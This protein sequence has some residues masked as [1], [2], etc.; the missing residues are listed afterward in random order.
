M[1]QLESL[2]DTLIK[3]FMM[4]FTNKK[5]QHLLLNIDIIEIAFSCLENA[6][7]ISS[8]A[9]INLAR[10]ISIIFKFP[11]VQERL[12]E[13]QVVQGIVHLLKCN[14]KEFDDTPLF[15]YTLKTCAL[16]SLN[17]K[18]V[19]SHLSL[20]ILQALM[21]LYKIYQERKKHLSYLDLKSNSVNSSHPTAIKNISQDWQN[22][23]IE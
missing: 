16:I 21:P 6:Q 17:F 8:E 10:L 11:Q 7:L 19:N 1:D 14:L 23:F 5:S 18:F 2:R 12:F 15:H 4:I 13:E 3:S 9:K 20:P 22:N